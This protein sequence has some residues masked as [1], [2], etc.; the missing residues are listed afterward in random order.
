MF[1]TNC[2]NE[3]DE[4]SVFCTF[5]GS[6]ILNSNHKDDRTKATVSAAGPRPS[7]GIE[8]CG[9]GKYRWYYELSMLK[10]PVILITVLKV[11]GLV[12]GI[13]F[14]FLAASIVKNYS[15]GKLAEYA[16]PA[17]LFILFFTV[18]IIV[19][20]L[21]LAA[22]FGGK[23]LVLFEMNE[24]GV[25]HI[26]MPA[27]FK[28]VQAVAWLSGAAGFAIGDP[29]GGIGRGLVIGTK[30]ES[31]T[32]FSHVSKLRSQPYF[33]TIK[34]VEILNHNQIYATNEDYNFVLQYILE[35]IPQ[36]ARRN[37]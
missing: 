27:Q 37:V 33:N 28:K 35:H 16:V 5:C 20:Y 7:P 10:N 26:Q 4:D 34:L 24:E 21:V 3:I 11:F 15:F 8:L 32:D 18:L 29:I 12:F 25:R 22:M 1:C 36:K 2:G 31:Y 14:L 30:N 6:R 9:D 17:L 23:Y 13:L 19:S